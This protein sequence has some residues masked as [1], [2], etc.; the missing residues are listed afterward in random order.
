MV[1]DRELCNLRNRSATEV[2]NQLLGL[3]FKPWFLNPKQIL[4]GTGRGQ[5]A[6]SSSPLRQEPAGRLQ[7]ASAVRCSSNPADPS[8]QG[9]RPAGG[10]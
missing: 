9:G 10:D 1:P 7:R 6:C 3:G 5:A 4:P 8:G 2:Q